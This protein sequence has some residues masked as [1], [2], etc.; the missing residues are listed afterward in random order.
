LLFVCLLS[1]A[2]A[3]RDRHQHRCRAAAIAGLRPAADSGGRL[4]LDARLLGLG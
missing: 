3:N 1:R 4:H 2:S